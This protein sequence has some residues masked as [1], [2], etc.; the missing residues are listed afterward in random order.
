VLAGIETEQEALAGDPAGQGRQRVQVG[1]HRNVEQLRADPGD[2]GLAGDGAQIEP[3]DPIWPRAVLWPF[4]G[5][6]PAHLGSQARLA[7][8]PD[9]GQ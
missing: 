3:P 6:A 1:L 4:G 9:A 7:A 5:G 2:V 8:A